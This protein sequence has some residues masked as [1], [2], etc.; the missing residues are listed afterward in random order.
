MYASYP[1]VKSRLCPR[2]RSSLGWWAK[3]ASAFHHLF[4]SPRVLTGEL[5]LR[6]AELTT[7]KAPFS[8]ND[9]ASNYFHLLIVLAKQST[10]IKVWFAGKQIAHSRW[11]VCVKN[12]LLTKDGS[13]VL[14][15]TKTK[16]LGE[17]VIEWKDLINVYVNVFFESFMYE[18][19][20]TE[21][22]RPAFKVSWH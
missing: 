9:H 17:V 18:K 2:L 1:P 22:E 7:I 10:G 4:S 8:I 20:E 19:M 14:G 11:I 12:H 3:F 15:Q 16:L 6:M 21:I 5:S 13:M